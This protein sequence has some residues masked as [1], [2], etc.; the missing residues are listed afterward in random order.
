M[1][2]LQVLDGH[3]A[4]VSSVAFSPA[5]GSTALASI[6]WDGTLRL[7]DA[8][9]QDNSRESIKL[10]SEGCNCILFSCIIIKLY[11]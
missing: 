6:S 3:E 7:W 5:L 10:T 2:K 1:I 9:A 11:K 4:P 8:I